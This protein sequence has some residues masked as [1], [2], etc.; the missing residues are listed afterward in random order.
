M[1]LTLYASEYF[2]SLKSAKH[3]KILEAVELQSYALQFKQLTPQSIDYLKQFPKLNNYQAEAADGPFIDHA[4]HTPKGDKGKVYAARFIYAMNLRNGLLRSL[5]C[6]TKALN[7]ARKHPCYVVTLSNIIALQTDKKSISMC[8]IR[9][10]H[11]LFLVA[12]PV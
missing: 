4:Y 10:N 11:G 9:H 12:K 2:K 1:I 6:I 7:A 5:C 3:T 8:M